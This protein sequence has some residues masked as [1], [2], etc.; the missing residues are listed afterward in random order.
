MPQKSLPK[1]FKKVKTDIEFISLNKKG[2]F[3][4]GVFQST[5]EIP[6]TKFD[7]T[8]TVWI[9]KESETGNL[10]YLPEKATMR[11][12]QL[13]LKAGMEFLIICN[14]K[15]T[16]EKGQKYYTFDL[17]LPDDTDDIPF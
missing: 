4:Q 13:R 17:H 16:G 14:G 1:G 3:F 9:C 10:V 11:D 7:L 15:S 8:Q 6:S 2:D 12:L 5:K